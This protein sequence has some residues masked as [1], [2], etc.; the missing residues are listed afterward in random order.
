MIIDSSKVLDSLDSKPRNYLGS[1]IYIPRPI[2]KEGMSVTAPLLPRF[3]GRENS[4]FQVR[5]PKRFLSMTQRRIASQQRHIWGSEVYT[6][7]SD[8]LTVLMHTGR[9]PTGA[10]PELMSSSRKLVVQG[11]ISSTPPTP[12]TK[13][14]APTPTSKEEPPELRPGQDLLVD[15]II[16]PTLEMYS[17]TTRFGI[18]SRSWKTN[19][20][21]MSYSIWGLQWVPSGEAESR[22]PGSKKRRLD[23]REHVRKWGEVPKS[24]GGAGGEG[25]V[26]N[27]WLKATVETSMGVA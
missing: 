27:T 6:D 23:E 10:E 18:K 20:D 1:I 4:I 12:A 16:L 9:I 14:G 3:E 13:W 17:G 24:L 25:W 22:G 8:V 21:G 11:S 19:H 2:P 26:K 15:L 5:I 7:D